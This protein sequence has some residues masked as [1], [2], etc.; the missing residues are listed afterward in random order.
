MTGITNRLLLGLEQLLRL[1]VD[2]SKSL[3][4]NWFQALVIATEALQ[5]RLGGVWL[6][7]GTRRHLRSRVIY[8]RSTHQLRPN[9]SLKRDDHLTYFKT[10]ETEKVLAAE[11]MATD[12]R[13]ASFAAYSQEFGI[14]SLLDAPLFRNGLMIGVV[15]FESE[16]SPREWPEAEEHFVQATSETL[17]RII[18]SIENHRLVEQL[19][20]LNAEMQMCI[21]RTES[22]I[23]TVDHELRV[24]V[25]NQP[26]IDFW[27][28]IQVTTNTGDRIQPAICPISAVV[29]AEARRVWA[30]EEI[31][32]KI[33][34]VLSSG[35]RRVMNIH[36]RPINTT[37]GVERILVEVRA[38]D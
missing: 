23:M 30:G 18:E 1:K 20:T 7:D 22:W 31:E 16:E 5:V 2:A 21:N 13:M 19:A 24:S 26:L 15:C 8:D 29:A 35:S 25:L 11:S 14:N 34:P 28:L 17:V 38:D 12:P 3:E 27:R 32:R 9:I 36:L 37:R 6:F 33:N 4:M 10:L